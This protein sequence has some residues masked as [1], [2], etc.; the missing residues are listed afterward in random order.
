MQ[1]NAN[2]LKTP[3][4]QRTNYNVQTEKQR[5]RK[6]KMTVTLAYGPRANSA[7]QRTYLNNVCVPTECLATLGDR[8]ITS[9]VLQYSELC[10]FDAPH[11]S[12]LRSLWNLFRDHNE[13]KEEPQNTF[14]T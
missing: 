6:Q 4:Y 10:T 13:S 7:D 3:S 8:L 2:N 5:W 11:K 9:R 1:I 14:L 12:G